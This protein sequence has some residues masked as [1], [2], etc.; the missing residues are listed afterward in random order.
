MTDPKDPAAELFEGLPERPDFEPSQP[1]PDPAKASTVARAVA[2]AKATAQA[3][4]DGW[5]L[6][7]DDRAVE[8]A[9]TALAIDPEN[10]G[11]WLALANAFGMKR[12]ETMLAGG[13]RAVQ[14][15]AAAEKAI[16]AELARGRGDKAWLKGTLATELEGN[17][18]PRVPLLKY[19]TGDNSHHWLPGGIVG[20]VVASGGSGKTTWLTELAMRVVCGK[21]W[22]EGLWQLATKPGENTPVQGPALVVLA[23]EDREGAATQIARARLHVGYHRED[24]LVLW[25]GAGHDAA[26]GVQVTIDDPVR[27]RITTVVPSP[28][29]DA[30]CERARELGPLL[31]VL[32]PLNQLLPIGG[33]E[34]DAVTAGALIKLA[35]QIQ[36]AAEEG[37][38]RKGCLEGYPRPVVLIAHHEAKRQG[39]DAGA[40]ATRGS[41]AFVDNARWVCRM[42]TT[43]I[44]GIGQAWWKVDKSNYTHSAKAIARRRVAGAGIVWNPWTLEDASEWSEAEKGDDTANDGATTAPKSGRRRRGDQGATAAP[45][46]KASPPASEYD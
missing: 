25:H 11:R 33:S 23:E 3:S 27:G 35:G 38:Q 15:L 36:A 5:R 29:H 14:G 34:N 28:F 6:S 21:S 17:Q 42:G 22:P 39:E 18:R 24:P 46:A 2:A 8:L 12:V 4:E 41:T 43:W 40:D 13:V 7:S 32:D 16:A 1:L 31:V 19:G 20:L 44:A 10:V 30:L 45:P 26:L 37:R 9:R